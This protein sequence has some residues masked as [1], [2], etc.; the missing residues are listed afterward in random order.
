MKRHERGF[1]SLSRCDL[2][3]TVFS[4]ILAGV[5]LHPQ[6]VDRATDRPVENRVAKA[7]RSRPTTGIPHKLIQLPGTSPGIE[8]GASYLCS[9]EERSPGVGPRSTAPAES[10]VCFHR[11]RSSPRG[12]RSVPYHLG[13]PSRNGQRSLPFGTAGLEGASTAGCSLSL[14]AP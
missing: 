2:R 1:L 3:K 9:G 8:S 4:S 12:R 13:A 6:I 14:L 10:I 11:R 7:A 5:P